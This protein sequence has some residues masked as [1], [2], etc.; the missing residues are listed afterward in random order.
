MENGMARS[1]AWVAGTGIVALVGADAWLVCTGQG[2]ARAAVELCVGGAGLV[3]AGV[4]W[5]VH[6]VRGWARRRAMDKEEPPAWAEE[7]EVETLREEA[8]TLREEV[9][10]LRDEVETLRGGGRVPDS[11]VAVVNLPGDD[12][13]LYE[14]YRL[15][16]AGSRE[17]AMEAARGSLVSREC[18][19]L[20]TEGAV[21][22]FLEGWEP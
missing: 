18:E 3:S 7:S 11:W 19:G 22:T 4:A 20:A 17:E 1:L 5:A 14:A 21:V 12:G 8:E 9:D 2:G 15:P 6:G 10:T 16:A 13:K